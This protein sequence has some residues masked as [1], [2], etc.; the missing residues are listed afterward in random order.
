MPSNDTNECG[1]ISW[2][3]SLKYFFINW[4]KFYILSHTVW[5]I[6]VLSW[7]FKVMHWILKHFPFSSHIFK[8]ASFLI[9]LFRIS[10]T[11][12]RFSGRSRVE[13]LDKGRFNLRFA[14]SFSLKVGFSRR[15]S[16]CESTRKE[17]LREKHAPR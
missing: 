12:W 9:T 4:W 11:N 6:C 10:R 14:K 17:K 16:A 15:M 5:V 13:K 7:L 2:R 1:A 8:W 3:V